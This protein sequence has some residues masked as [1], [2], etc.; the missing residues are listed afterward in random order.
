M[1]IVEMRSDG[2]HAVSLLNETKK[3]QVGPLQ[4]LYAAELTAPVV[5][6]AGAVQR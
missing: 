4:T 2:V 1:Q 5:H 3:V 6:V